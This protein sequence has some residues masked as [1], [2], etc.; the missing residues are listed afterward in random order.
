MLVNFDELPPTIRMKWVNACSTIFAIHARTRFELPRHSPIRRSSPTI[1][2]GARDLDPLLEKG[3][4]SRKTFPYESQATCWKIYP[5]L[6]ERPHPSQ[7]GDPPKT[8]ISRSRDV[9]LDETHEQSCR[10]EIHAAG[11]W[12]TNPMVSVRCT[13][14]GKHRNPCWCTL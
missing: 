3:Q 11:S 13:R 5:S 10:G 6:I 1:R 7:V 4:L 9:E 2:P 14:R 8:G 12:S